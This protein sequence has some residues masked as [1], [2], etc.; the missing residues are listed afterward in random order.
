MLQ[1]YQSLMTKKQTEYQQSLERFKNSQSQ[2]FT[3]QQHRIEMV[4]YSYIFSS[5]EP[6]Q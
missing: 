2:Q 1:H 5:T 3:E 4:I 6:P